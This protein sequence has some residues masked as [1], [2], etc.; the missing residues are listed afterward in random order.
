MTTATVSNELARIV[1]ESGLAASKAAAL[2]EAMGPL[3]AEAGE[4]VAQAASITVT[5]A[6]Q[7]TEMREAR[8]LRLKLK[9]V[10]VASEKAR[11]ELK[12]D[13]LATGKAI[14]AAGN[15]V[16]GK[17]EPVEARLLDCEEFAERAEAARK[18][19]LKTTR[20]QVLAPFVLDLTGYDLA[21]MPEATFAQLHESVRLAQQAKIDAAAKA[22]ADRVR[23]EAERVAREEATKAEN[24]RLRVASE[25]EAKA[26]KAEQEEAARKLKAVQDAA[27]AEIE[28]QRK[29]KEAL[30]R[31]A[32]VKADAEAKRL[33]DEA[34][35]RKKA[36]A[37]P[38]VDKIRAYMRAVTELPLSPLATPYARVEAF[39]YRHAFLACLESLAKKI[40]GAS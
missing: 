38:D 26:R 31:E 37:A 24:E 34:K 4:L 3:V 33:A 17:I 11:K 20:E 25:A 6:T 5:D 13:A 8:A 19:A 28:K 39:G 18:A 32:K 12:A 2:M 14:D 10:R 27:D 29:A 36:E 22:E 9:D 1:T 35:A 30:E 15:W 16:K 7:V 21:N 40:G 23:L